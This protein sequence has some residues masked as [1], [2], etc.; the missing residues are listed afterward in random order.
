[1]AELTTLSCQKK[2]EDVSNMTSAWSLESKSALNAA[3]CAVERCI[4]ADEIDEVL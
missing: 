1:M 3:A 4:E 2:L